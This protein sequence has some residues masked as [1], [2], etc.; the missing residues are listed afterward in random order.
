MSP[1]NAE[2]IPSLCAAYRQACATVAAKCE[3]HPSLRAVYGPSFCLSNVSSG[4]VLFL[5]LMQTP[6]QYLLPKATSYWPIGHIVPE[7]P[8]RSIWKFTLTPPT[9]IMHLFR[10]PMGIPEHKRNRAP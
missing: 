10:P 3:G 8:P 2:N 4:T 6:E 7:L 1:S 5:T 9:G